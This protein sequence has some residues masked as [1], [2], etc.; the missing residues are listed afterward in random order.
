MTS[1]RTP[2]SEIRLLA[3]TERAILRQTQGRW[4]VDTHHAQTSSTTDYRTALT[5]GLNEMVG[6]MGALMDSPLSVR[7]GLTG[8]RD[9]R[10]VLAALLAAHGTD[11]RRLGERVEF[12]CGVAAT[13]DLSVATRLSDLYGLDLNARKASPGLRVDPGAG[14]HLW[15]RHDLGVNAALWPVAVHRGGVVLTGVGGEE[16]RLVYRQSTMA[17]QLRMTQTKE[18]SDARMDDLV[19]SMEQSLASVP[20]DVDERILHHRLF[21]NRFH[22]GRMPM[23]FLT[24]SPLDSLALRA[25]S[26]HLDET[27]AQTAQFH[28]DIILN[29]APVLGL[30]PHDLDSK[31][32]TRQNEASLTRVRVDPQH[33]AGRVFGELP[34]A[35]PAASSGSHAMDPYHE[36]FRQDAA[37]VRDSGLVPAAVVD[38]AQKVLDRASP[39]APTHANHASSLST[40]LLVGEVLRLQSS[41]H[42]PTDPRRGASASVLQRATRGLRI[43]LPGRRSRASG[44]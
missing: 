39:S 42:Q 34:D 10:C 41:T 28:A 30:Q 9:S 7:S 21:R 36:A 33:A 35:P 11:P 43:A 20:S 22:G 13:K 27:A 40:T 32:I 19:S 37:A 44:G 17:E 16:H 12:Y 15:R 26:S 8:G 29:L 1:A 31:G 5:K 24:L 14:Y 23:R 25:A 38:R 6:L 3:P 2:F 4:E 18:V